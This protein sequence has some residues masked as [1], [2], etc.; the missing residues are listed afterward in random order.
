MRSGRMVIALAVLGLCGSSPLAAQARFN[1]I[2]GSGPSDIWVVGDRPVALHYDGQAWNEVSLGVR[3]SGELR[4]IWGSGPGD[5]FVV[6]DGGMILRYDGRAWSRMTSPTDR[7]LVA[8][9]GRSPSEVYAVAQS[10]SEGE[11]PLLLRYDGR[12]WSASALPLAFRAAGILL[13]AGEVL[14]AGSLGRDPMDTERRTGGVLARMGAAGWRTLG[15]DGQRVTDPVLGAAGW[16]RFSA[17]GSALLLLG[18]REDDTP[19]LAI[20]SGPGAAWT[21]LPPP[22]SAMSDT[23]VALAFLAGD[24]TPIALYDGVGFARFVGGRWAA[25]APNPQA[26]MMRLMQ[27]QQRD[28]QAQQQLQQMMANPMLM[29][30]RMAAFD[31]SDATAA[32]GPTARDFYVVTDEGRVT[33]VVEDQATIVY[34]ASCTDP[35]MAAMNPICQQLQAAPPRQ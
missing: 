9:A 12:T 22:V 17:G 25:V 29:G 13:A 33:R 2:W 31:M 7:D 14:V 11:P 24:G 4:A 18:M 20:A 26:E 32:W 15:W 16:Q 35:M 3:I 5:V 1:A 21:L 28:P 10:Q 19:A 6:G 8:V 30:L 34:D 27:Q 23:R